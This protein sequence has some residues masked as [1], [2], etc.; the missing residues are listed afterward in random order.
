MYPYHYHQPYPYD[1]LAEPEPPKTYNFVVVYGMLVLFLIF[2]LQIGYEIDK[3]N[4]KINT[5]SDSLIV[6]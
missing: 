1:Q 3:A 6:Q 5:Q 4:A 2:I